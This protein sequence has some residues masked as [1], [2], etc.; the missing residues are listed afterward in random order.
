MG[1]DPGQGPLSWSRRAGPFD[2]RHRGLEPSA[3]TCSEWTNGKPARCPPGRGW[4][5]AAHRT[6]APCRHRR[7]RATCVAFPLAESFIEGEMTTPTGAA[8][9]TTVVERFTALPP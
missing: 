2:C 9:L 1:I 3:S 8:I 4:V 6:H 7:R 5:K